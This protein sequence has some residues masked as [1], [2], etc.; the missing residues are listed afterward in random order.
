MSRTGYF[1]AIPRF[2]LEA[3]QNVTEGLRGICPAATAIAG[4]PSE[5]DRRL[6][7]APHAV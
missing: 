7:F 3:F 6:L 4:D 1:R 2:D 5:V